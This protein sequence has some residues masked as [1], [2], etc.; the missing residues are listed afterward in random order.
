[1]TRIID[2]ALFLENLGSYGKDFLNEIIQIFFEEHQKDLEAIANAIELKNAKQL[3]FHAHKLKS[4]FRNFSN[5][6]HP[7]ELAYKLEIMGKEGDFSQTQ[8]IFD[9]LLIQ[10][11]YFIND[12][13]EIKDEL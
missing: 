3:N 4:T 9:E 2:K 13:K 1:M 5:P 6:C 11:S 8:E 7:A 12:L 10:T